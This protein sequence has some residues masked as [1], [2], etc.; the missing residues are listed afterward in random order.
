VEELS[1]F[2]QSLAKCP[3]HGL[4]NPLKNPS[5]YLLYGRICA[6]AAAA[7]QQQQVF[8]FFTKCIQLTMP[9][10][11]QQ[12]EGEVKV[13]R[14]FFENFSG[15]NVR[16]AL[17]GHFVAGDRE[18][19]QT[20][21]Y[22][23]PYGPVA[24]ISP[25]NFPL[26]IPVMQMM[27]ALFAGNKPV[28]KAESR[29]GLPLE[30]FFRFL[31]YCGMPLED[32]DL[33]SARGPVMSEL[34]RRSPI[35]LLQFTGSTSVA[36]ELS[37]LLQGRVRIED[38]GFN[39]KVLGKDI[40]PSEQQTLAYVAWQ[41]DEDAYA[42]S[43][44][45]CSAQSLLFVHRNWVAA[46]LLEL[47]AAAAARR[48]LQTLTICPLLSLN[49]QQMHRHVQALLSLKGACLLFGGYPL[50]Q[51]QQQQQQHSVPP[52]FGLYAPTAVL[53]PLQTLAFDA[54]A[55]KVALQE[56]FGPLQ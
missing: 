35:R 39:F 46:G 50:Q 33:I 14:S 7:L 43:G 4:H 12:A 40:N 53:L 5:R 30:Q 56:V 16:F 9:K 25:F 37:L 8:S 47:L 18:G 45:K 38:G 48:S 20:Q 32:A 51:Q 41:A 29:Q 1:P 36:R 2:V 42:L 19:Q 21:S 49:N 34:L 15:D 26:E 54:A 10:S 11:Q 52:Q 23:W 31:H 27:G 17:K 13:L 55:R 44:Q 3:K 6:A 28:V 24:I 22:R